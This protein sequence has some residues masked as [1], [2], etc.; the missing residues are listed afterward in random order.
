MR[1][2][3]HLVSERLGRTKLPSE[4]REEVVEE[5]ALHF[6]ECYDELCEV[7][8]PDPEGYTL[9]QV[10]DWKALGRKIRRAKEGLMNKSIRILVCGMLTGSLAAVV[11]V[12][13][14]FLGLLVFSTD[15][16]PDIAATGGPIS[17]ATL[18]RWVGPMIVMAGGVWTIWLYTLMR[19][20]HRPGTKTSAMTGLAAWIVG[21]LGAAFFSSLG[22]IP[23]SVFLGAAVLGLPAW[24]AGTMAG[25]WF[26]EA[27][28]RKPAPALTPA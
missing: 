23:L 26:Y 3:K 9:A 6:E 17:P 24:I 5:I 1:D 28:E 21:V 11:A 7:G 10:P 27:S 14:N 12:A 4:E 15:Y 8:S 19:S 20:S 2:W 22:H 18:A 16:L 25:A 13:A